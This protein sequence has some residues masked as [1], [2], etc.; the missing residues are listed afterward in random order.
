MNREELEQ[1][2]AKLEKAKRAFAKAEQQKKDDIR[3][4]QTEEGK[5]IARFSE[6]KALLSI[7]E[8][9][10]KTAQHVTELAK[11]RRDNLSERFEVLRKKAEVHEITWIL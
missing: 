3:L 8:A 11:A 5:L 1:E 4:T 6:L 10:Y 9:E 7:A 2:K